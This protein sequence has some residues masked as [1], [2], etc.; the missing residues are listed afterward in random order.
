M[1][2]TLCLF[3]ALILAVGIC[4]SAPV[5]IT[6]SAAEAVSGTCGAS[7][8]TGGESSVTW[9]Y[10]SVT[11]TLT[12]SGSGAM[13]D[14]T[15]YDM[16]W[17]NY[18]SNIKEVV[19]ENGVT[20]I[21]NIAFSNCTSLIIVT[22]P[23]SVT[24]IAGNAFEGC[25]AI[26]IV[27]VPC[28]WEGETAGGKTVTKHH[29]YNDENICTKCGN[30]GA[31]FTG[32]KVNDDFSVT[33]F[34]ECDDHYF[35]PWD[36]L[37]I[38]VYNGDQL[39]EG[40]GNIAYDVQQGYYATMTELNPD[41]KG[42]TLTA[43]LIIRGYYNGH[44]KTSTTVEV[45]NPNNHTGGTATCTEKAV[46]DTCGVSY[47]E[48]D[49]TNHDSSVECVNGFC[50]NGCYEPATLNAEGY[51]EIDNAGKLFW[52]ANHVN[53]V[54]RTASAV[55]VADIDLED[56]PWTPIGETGEENNNFCGVFDGQGYTI[57][58]LNV[59]GS[60]NGVG[61][62]GEVR[63]GTVKNFTIYGN[64][65]VNT[66]VNY[67]GGVIGSICGLNSTDHGLER[68]GA[69]IQNITSFVNVT[70]KAHGIGMIGGFVGYAN[71]Q[72]L[73]EQCAW[74]GTFD[75]GEYRVVSGAGGFIGKIQEN[76]S[77]VTIRNCGAYGTIKTGYE[78][79]SYNNYTTIYMGGFLSFSNMGAQTT[80]E[81]CL[82]AGKF[83]KGENLTDQ[84]FLG[85]FGTLRS[86]KAIK[87]CYYLG[88]DGL[89]AVHS[90]S[91]LK[92]GSDN[93]EITSVTG[94]ELRNN[95]IA[96]QLGDHWMQDV[97]YPIPKDTKAHGDSATY[98]YTDN[99]DGTHD[100][101]CNE[102]GY[103]EV[104]NEAHTYENGK[105]TA[106]GCGYACTHEEGEN[107]LCAVCKSTSGSCGENVTWVYDSTTTTL[108][109]SGTGAMA[110]YTG[111]DDTPWYNYHD[112]ITKVVIENG[113]TT[114]GK[115]A[116]DYCGFLTS[117]TIPESV[118]SIGDF[119]FADCT[120]LAAVTIPDSITTIGAGAFY[121]CIKLISITIPESVTTISNS[122]FY[123]C[124][125]LTSIE[126]DVNNS[127]YLS[128]DN[129]VL[130]NKDKTELICYPVGKTATSYT[131]PDGVKSIGD[132]AFYDCTSLTTIEI[133]DSVTTIGSYAFNGCTALASVTIPD[134]VETIGSQAF[135]Y[136]TSLTTVSAPCSWNE[137]PLYTFE[138]GVKV[139]IPKHTIENNN[140]TVCKGSKCGATESD[141]VTW[142]YD[143][144]TL[145][146]N[147][148]GAMVGDYDGSNMPWYSY[149]DKITKIII[150]NGVTTIGMSAF[151][152][153]DNLTSVTIPK[154]VTTIGM[155]A[156]SGCGLTSVTIPDGVTTIGE[157]AF[158]GCS[159]LTSV[160]IGNG[161][162]KI[163]DYAFDGCDALTTVNVPCDWDT[164]NP[165]YAFAENVLKKCH[166][167]VIDEAKAPTCEAIGWDAYEH[168]TACDYTTYKEKAKLG[169]DKVSHSAKS[170]T[171]EAIGWYAYDTC[172]RC[173]YTTYKEIA[174]LGHDIVSHSAKSATCEA[175]GWYAYDT[176]SRCDY[177]TYKEIAKLGH[178]IVIDKAV[179]PTCTKTGL[180][181][182]SHCTRCDDKTVAQQTI[183]KKAHTEVTVT[184]KAATC[185]AT[186]LTDGKKCS[187]CGVTTVE[188]KE[189]AALGHAYA[190]DFTTDKEPTYT[191]AGSKSKHCSRC[192]AKTEVTAIAKKVLATPTVSFTPTAKGF[193]IN[194]NKV[195][196]AQSY[197]VY[198]KTYNASTKKWS[199]WSRL[200]SG[201]TSTSCTDTS[202]KL[203]SYYKYTVK[204]VN[205]K[206]TSTFITLN[207]KKYNVTPDVKVAV[208]SN[209]IKVS[210][211]TAA[212]ATGYRVYSS[213][214]N[215][216]TKKWSG[217]TNRGTTKANATSWVDKSVKSG[218][219][220][221]YTV[222]AMNDKVGSAYNKDGAA[223]L[224]LAQ[225][226]VKIAN[227]ASGVKLSWNKIA[228]AT[229]YTVYRSE[230]SNGKWTSWKNMGT[231]K[232]NSTVSWVD[233][234]VKS[235]T[236]YRYTVR[237]INGSVKSTYK[238]SNILLYLAQPTTT[239]KAVSNGINVAWSQCEG[240]TG[241]TVYR[242]EY[243]TKTKKWSGWK[244]MGTAK[245]DKKSWTDKSAKKGVIY[246]YTVRSVNADTGA[247]SSYVA[248]K[249]V[250]R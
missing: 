158:Y 76:T 209:G 222:K 128:D 2:R 121:F 141:T 247:K 86:V 87:N 13:A 63:T 122:A 118:T 12:I 129:G 66:E 194:W 26:T 178:D 51:Y 242:S 225:P 219:K 197:I 238:A 227:N 218:T 101:V 167:I 138:D 88:D 151:S 246:K 192:D 58:G 235:G 186:G 41:C 188:Q 204:A 200:K 177:T 189:I 161:E 100:K 90:D 215:T 133:P 182:G 180:T 149:Q 94:E 153:C 250:K 125:A 71:H 191:E 120:S 185:T 166:N 18:Q 23:S 202:V 37:Q 83:E 154:S 16:P 248:S 228:G 95:T 38:E 214:Y 234:S 168:C 69:V 27:N 60:E 226:T 147:G 217:W 97:H 11:T 1:K 43:D 169:H 237:A 195:E 20:T 65:V 130:F 111:Y 28:I 135:S 92:P 137:K 117:V 179:A 82:F 72:S 9:A 104:D 85:A 34:V 233:K 140:C 193:E 108:T 107:G 62:F 30:P 74:Y 136:C 33:F 45:K 176:C 7:T 116:F 211:S 25:D 196:G 17:Y 174:K 4:F 46:C 123:S 221:R 57:R 240:A 73:I 80:L 93:V 84:A 115:F 54:D 230:L 184:G 249:N 172:S 105:C 14:Y 15:G 203:G 56:K 198:K 32:T 216:K 212:N 10:D 199:G 55:L 131:I 152:G 187:V 19:I 110:D 150:E 142:V 175:I 207:G 3:L 78:K 112:D 144:G 236:Q 79:N 239:V 106:E 201:V 171:C 245:S 134:S 64:V 40:L 170:A 163:Y 223:T 164:E 91:D 145:Y 39:V 210:W 220:Y 205:G 114:I 155:S 81:N 48:V 109:I 59:E 103:V 102:C 162:T 139:V 98:T 113:V 206:E 68:N 24:T 70:A 159:K 229:G 173:D 232:K 156:F 190:K 165:P 119:A 148:T 132:I 49:T 75:A 143:E 42:I 241:Y 244:S 243:N 124:T 183:A 53:T 231:I 96:S 44:E 47:G 77:E 52:F 6:A 208:A 89:E 22:I 146:I 157:S 5:T 8:N 181:E 127:T 29:D 160:T 36:Q 61:F 126:V 224:Y 21:G 67:V 35:V 99:G 31:W 213:T 50:P